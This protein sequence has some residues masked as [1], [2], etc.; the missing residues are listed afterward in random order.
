MMVVGA[1][2]FDTALGLVAATQ[3]GRRRSGLLV[4]AT[5]TD[6]PR[7]SLVLGNGN[8]ANHSGALGTL[9]G[10]GHTNIIL[11]FCAQPQII[12]GFA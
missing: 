6:S 11:G 2:L 7:R 12:Q 9:V 5:G 8:A 1:G 4:R 10:A 3:V